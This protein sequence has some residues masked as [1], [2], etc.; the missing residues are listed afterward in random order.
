[1]CKKHSAYWRRFVWIRGL[2]YLSSEDQL[3]YIKSGMKKFG[4]K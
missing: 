2:N 1:M 3:K 4:L